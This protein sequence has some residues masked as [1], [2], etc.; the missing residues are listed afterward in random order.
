L[1]TLTLNQ[2]SDLPDGRFFYPKVERSSTYEGNLSARP[3]GDN[4]LMAEEKHSKVTFRYRFEY[5]GKSD[6]GLQKGLGLRSN[7][8]F[9]DLTEFSGAVVKNSAIL[10]KIISWDIVPLKGRFPRIKLDYDVT[11]D[12]VP[13][14]AR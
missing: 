4:V 11:L 14:R 1:T 5:T 7:K 12:G 3:Q 9:G 2:C 10:G 13:E 8:F 6:Q